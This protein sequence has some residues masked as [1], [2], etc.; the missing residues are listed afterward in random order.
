MQWIST[1]AESGLQV[2]S[3]ALVALHHLNKRLLLA[4]PRL[5]PEK[6]VDQ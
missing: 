3:D 1:V 6:I 2:G 5:K 4:Q